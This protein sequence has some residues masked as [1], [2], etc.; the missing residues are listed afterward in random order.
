METESVLVRSGRVLD[1][2]KVS[3]EDTSSHPQT[4]GS[5]TGTSHTQGFITRPWS[6]RF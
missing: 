5:F 2:K 3:A 4:P 6:Q 1:P